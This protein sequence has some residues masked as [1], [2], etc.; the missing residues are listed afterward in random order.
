MESSVGSGEFASSMISGISVQPRT[1]AS[2]PCI[3]QAADDLL[4]VGD[5]L[6]LEHAVDQLVH[7][8]A[9]DLV[10]LGVGSDAGTR[11]PAASFSG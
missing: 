11:P 1:T 2:Q 3:L 7:D 5:V 4:E 6:G 10:A 9:V 8:D